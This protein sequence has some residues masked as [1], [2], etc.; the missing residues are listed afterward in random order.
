MVIGEAADEFVCKIV[1]MGEKGMENRAYVLKT[2]DWKTSVESKKRKNKAKSQQIGK[3]GH[4][5]KNKV[6]FRRNIWQL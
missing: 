2:A 5:K 1:K 6:N 4:M 3:P